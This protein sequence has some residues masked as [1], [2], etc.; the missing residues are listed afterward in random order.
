ML[1]GRT[2]DCMAMG[3]D[4][5]LL[6]IDNKRG[7]IRNSRYVAFA[8][9]AAELIELALTEC[10]GLI[11]GQLTVVRM[12]G[13]ANPGLATSL[14]KIAD[15]RQPVTVAA[16]LGRH[17]E[18]GR[19]RDCVL[20]L[21][22]VGAVEVDDLSKGVAGEQAMQVHFA[23][24]MPAQ[25]AVD[26]FVAVARGALT[27]AADE[28][29]AALADAAGLTQAHLHGLSNRRARARI[30]TLTAHRAEPPVE[31]GRTVLAIARAAVQAMAESARRAGSPG[32]IGSMAI[33]IDKQ[34]VMRQDIQALLRDP[35]I[36]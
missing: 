13:A 14:T 4:L 7:E 11:G 22:R 20:E 5:V 26:R 10:I 12:G 23:E 24:P 17:G 3:A 16:W 8:M 1:T 34:F 9:A 36:P 19:V 29:F 27:S 35:N 25:A 2:L 18:L 6:A 15:S 31:P 21:E 33:P 28:A 32:P 30:S